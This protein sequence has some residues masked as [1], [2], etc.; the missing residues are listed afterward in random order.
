MYGIF[1]HTI[2]YMKIKNEN[3]ITLIALVITVV[4]LG[5]LAGVAVQEFGGIL[6][7]VNKET[8]ST[9]L[10]LVQ[11]KAKVLNEK[12]SFDKDES[13]LK[14]QKL[15]EIT[16]NAEIDNLKSKGVISETEENYNQYY[17]WDKTV[18]DELEIGIEKMKDSD[19]FIVNYA[20]EEVI[21][22]KGYKDS[23]GNTY[24]KLSE[25]SALE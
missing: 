12:S 20:T 15:S 10:L 18:V 5:I 3:G 16:G 2:L 13:L 24:Y 1:Y 9:D 19:F 14:G 21:Y 11:A 22:P 23:E 8:V 6:D 4:V 17:V 7:Q 25:I